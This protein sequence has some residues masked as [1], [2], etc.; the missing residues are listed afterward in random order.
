MVKR[1]Q[2]VAGARAPVVAVSGV[3]HALNPFGAGL[4]SRL[5]ARAGRERPGREALADMVQRV[6]VVVARVLERAPD[7]PRYRDKRG[8]RG[9]K[10][11]ALRRGRVRGMFGAIRYLARRRAAGRP[12]HA[13][14]QIALRPRP[15]VVLERGVDNIAELV[16][17][18]LEYLRRMSGRPGLAVRPREHV[19]GEPVDESVRR[20]AR[21]ARVREDELSRAQF[22][23]SMYLPLPRPPDA[24]VRKKSA[25]RQIAEVVHVKARAF[26]LP[27]LLDVALALLKLGFAAPRVSNGV[28]IRRPRR[29]GF[30]NRAALGKE[31]VHPAAVGK[32]ILRLRVVTERLQDG[33]QPQADGFLV[34]MPFRYEL[35][36]ERP[37]AR[38]VHSQAS[39]PASWLLYT[40]GLRGERRLPISPSLVSRLN[41]RGGVWRDNH[42]GS[43][44]RAC[45]GLRLRERG[46][47]ARG[48]A[49]ARGAPSS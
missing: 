28:R 4:M 46:R 49:L 29:F 32:G 14:P 26:A 25:P 42:Q 24:P 6:V 19:G 40:L 38:F 31:Y 35:E 34:G 47:P 12:K 44:F 22:A 23:V 7:R 36:R 5:P 15:G 27:F 8:V 30:D 21:V 1:A 11:V 10:V 41:E 9:E 48:A 45:G 20:F 37:R 2:D 18:R 16:S 13:Q 17:E 43:R 33:G 39:V 3:E